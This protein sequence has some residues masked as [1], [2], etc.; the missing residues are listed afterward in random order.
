[1]LSGSGILKIS[2][3]RGRVATVLLSSLLFGALSLWCRFPTLYEWDS[4]NYVTATRSF[5]LYL[6]QPHPPGYI[7]F[8]MLLKGFIS[9]LNSDFYGFYVLVLLSYF[10]Y[11]LFSTLLF[12][13]LT[14]TSFNPAVYLLFL[15][16]PMVFFH[17]TVTTIYLT[18]GTTVLLMVYIL[19]KV[20][21]KKLPPLFVFAI[22]LAAP[23]KTNIPIVLLPL[24][25]YVLWNR[26]EKWGFRIVMVFLMILAVVAGQLGLQK[27]VFWGF[28][29]AGFT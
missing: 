20:F 11:V 21:Q 19:L 3:K 22:L 10:I 7:G 25:V 13:E 12:K 16:I 29:G 27:L 15:S 17:S 4:V 23:I 24:A 14:R 26:Y 9:L 28:T 8:V 5:N 18:E 1:M 2:E 6:I